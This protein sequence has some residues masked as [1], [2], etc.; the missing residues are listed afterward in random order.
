MHAL[1]TGFADPVISAST[2]LLIR[3]DLDAPDDAGG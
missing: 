2:D 1:S 3:A